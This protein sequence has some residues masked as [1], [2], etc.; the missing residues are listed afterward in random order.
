[1]MLKTNLSVAL[2]AIFF[3]VCAFWQWALSK[4]FVCSLSRIWASGSEDVFS[5][6]LRFQLP[7]QLDRNSWN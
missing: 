5:A 4:I 7:G 1:M 6:Y 2:A 3:T